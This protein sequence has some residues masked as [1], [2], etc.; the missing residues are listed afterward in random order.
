MNDMRWLP[1]VAWFFAGVFLTNGIPHFVSGVSGRAFQSPFSK[2]PGIGLSSSTANVVWGFF[3]AVI[4]YLLLCHVGSFDWH[5]TAD[6]IALGAGVL[7]MALFCARYFG[8][9]HGGDL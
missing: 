9:F 5:A 4:G 2:P 7:L 1:M 3:N 6:V 8:K